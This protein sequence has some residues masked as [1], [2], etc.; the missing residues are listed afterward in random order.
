MILKS[1]RIQEIDEEIVGGLVSPL[2]GSVASRGIVSL[3]HEIAILVD[4]RFFRSLFD[5]D[6]R[7]FYRFV[8]WCSLLFVTVFPVLVK[9]LPDI[10]N[11]ME[12]L[13]VAPLRWATRCPSQSSVPQ[14]SSKVPPASSLSVSVFSSH[15]LTE[16]WAVQLEQLKHG[17][18]P[19]EHFHFAANR[20]RLLRF[21]GES[22]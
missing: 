18:R 5:T 10:L 19:A 21:Y 13:P 1:Y 2:F 9:K 14:P 17:C 8:L 6:R 16:A 22:E 20:E 11:D 7:C 4:R 12:N 15:S 3:A